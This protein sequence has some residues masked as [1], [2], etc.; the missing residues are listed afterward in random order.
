MTEGRWVPYEHLLYLNRKLVDV[1]AGRTKR[2]MVMCPPR[3]GKSEMISRFFPAW[4]LGKFPDKRII[5]A[6]Y[7]A[8]FA[9]TWGRKARSLLEEF[10]PELFGVAV[11]KQSSA[12]SRWDIEGHEGGMATAGVR[13][14][15]TG[16]GAH[17]AIIDDPVKND[18]EANS[19]TYQEATW[20]WYRATL[21]TRL[22]EDG[23]IILVMTRW[24]EN[25]LAGK[26]LKAQEEGGDKWEIVR[27]PALAEE[28][29]PLGRRPGD[30]LCP[31]LFP[32][33]VLEAI[34]RRIG[35]YWWEALYQQR[36]SP[37][38]GRLFQRSWWRFYRQ[39]PSR[40]DQV[41]Q[42]WDMTFKD[43]KNADYV[44]GQ[45][46]GRVGADKYLLDQ[47]RDRMDFPTTI[48]AV[49]TLS[50]KWPQA[51]AKLIEDKANGPAVIATLRRSI[52][53]LIAVSPEGSKEERAAAV[54]PEVEAGNVY[55]PAPE[56]AP[57]IEDFIAECSAFPHGAHDDQVDAMTQ[58]LLRLGARRAIGPVDKPAG[59]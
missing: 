8:D 34:K 51:R 3:H 48:K 21:S 56:I 41:I 53:G 30:P 31:E 6:S 33:D 18:Q 54:A 43:G 2:L 17:V 32:R 14:P 52:P 38:K 7:E 42:S 10:G 50:A 26:L 37:P 55:L 47:I 25:D 1:V 15:I 49:R 44:V 12:A 57:W 40:F 23:A 5:L 29:D 24:N 20:D 58:A 11:S 16:K 36:P 4:Y 59:W 9:A 13:G 39:V 22:Q 28:E 45:V 27:L 19:E 35:S 46:W